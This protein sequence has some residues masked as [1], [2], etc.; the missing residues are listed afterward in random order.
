MDITHSK[1]IKFQNIFRNKLKLKN[2]INI[3]I[4]LIYQITY[5]VMNRI[6]I[7]FRKGI[8]EQLIY[9]KSMT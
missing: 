5:S 6:Q 8:L 9:N 1:I 7:S 2:R 3:E 4:G